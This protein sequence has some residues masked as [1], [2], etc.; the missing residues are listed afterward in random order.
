VKPKTVFNRVLYILG[1]PSVKRG[2]AH[3]PD[4][5]QGKITSCIF[6]RQ[7]LITCFSPS[8]AS[9]FRQRN[10]DVDNL[11]SQPQEASSLQTENSVVAAVKGK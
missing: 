3:R 7:F 1:L 10:A 9:P 5:L 6:L 4:V 8:V 11:V 2:K